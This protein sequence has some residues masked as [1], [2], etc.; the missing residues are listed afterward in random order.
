MHFDVTRRNI[1]LCDST[2]PPL[3]FFI[4]SIRLFY[5]GPP[6]F[7]VLLYI[8]TEPSNTP[9]MQHLNGFSLLSPFIGTTSDIFF[10]T[11]Y[12]F[13]SHH[14]SRHSYLNYFTFLGLH[15]ISSPIS[16]SALS[17]NT[18]SIRHDFGFGGKKIPLLSDVRL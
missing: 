16:Q 1:I 6:Y 18:I 15:S 13:M 3:S 2:I 10:L 14:P 5:T 11:L 7:P 12:P 8:C 9:N 4:T 17:V